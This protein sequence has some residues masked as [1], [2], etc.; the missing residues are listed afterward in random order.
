MAAVLSLTR[1]SV[2][3]GAGS[4]SRW[5]A[6]PKITRGLVL[7][8]A[9]LA[10][11]AGAVTYRSF[12][13]RS[14]DLRSATEQLAAGLERERPIEPRL[15]GFPHLP[16]R[17]MVRSGEG[18]AP[19]SLKLEA[20]AAR[21]L[22]RAGDDSPQALAARGTAELLRGDWNAAVDDLNRAASLKEDPDLLNNL[23]AAHL[24]RWLAT[25]QSAADRDDALRFAERA[26]AVDREHRGALF[27]R[28]LALE[29]LSPGQVVAAWRRYL[30]LD[31]SSAWAEEARGHL[32]PST[33]HSVASHRE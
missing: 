15:S 4:G 16:L 2:R 19:A 8:A 9:A 26:L 14:V 1:G 12:R 30:E 31:A 32:S 5:G 23:A 11:V 28:A 3:S 13:S 27:N 7:S 20:A 25:A 21:V 10:L 22:A 18:A 33:T 24:S 29:T 6:R 17:P